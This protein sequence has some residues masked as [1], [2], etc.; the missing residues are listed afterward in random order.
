MEA[1]GTA[2]TATTRS[3]PLPSTCGNQSPVSHAMLQIKKNDRLVFFYVAFMH[4]DP[5]T[6]F[7]LVRRP[8]I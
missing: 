7:V 2:G 4:N 8:S 6:Y 3:R 5:K 1:T